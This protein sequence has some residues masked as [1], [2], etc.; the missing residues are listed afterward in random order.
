MPRIRIDCRT[1]LPRPERVILLGNVEAAEDEERL[2]LQSRKFVEIL[3]NVQ[4]KAQ[5][6]T[7]QCRYKRFGDAFA[8]EKAVVEV[9]GRFDADAKTA[10][11][12]QLRRFADC[13][14]PC[15]EVANHIARCGE[16]AGVSSVCAG[17]FWSGAPHAREEGGW[18]AGSLSPGQRGGLG[19]KIR[20]AVVLQ[21][22]VVVRPWSSKQLHQLPHYAWTVHIA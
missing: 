16:G 17:D 18:D 5:W 6:Q 2:Y 4:P 21:V 22:A 19:R 1:L 11:V 20:R 7:A 15:L 13:V 14:I 8:I 3:L 10:Q 12:F 9:M